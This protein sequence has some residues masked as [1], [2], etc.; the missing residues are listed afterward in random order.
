[1][2]MNRQ[3]SEELFSL[4]SIYPRGSPQGPSQLRAECLI[5]GVDPE[6]EVTVRFV[7]AIERQVLDAADAPVEELVVTGGR[8]WP[9]SEAIV[10]EVRLS[11]LPNRT[12]A[13]KTAGSERAVLGENG[14]LAG[15]LVWRWEPL[16]G[17]VEAWTEEVRPGLCRVLVEVANRLEWDRATREQNA[18]R[19]LRSTH[20]A[21]YS[22]DSASSPPAHPPPHRKRS[23]HPALR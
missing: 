16:H 15:T 12:A 14:A 5:A 11:R 3:L 21:I 6:V 18:M 20:V 23:G 1:M 10:Q 7:Q 2:D 8:Y 19:T 22:P 9:G 17:T 4:G 13:I